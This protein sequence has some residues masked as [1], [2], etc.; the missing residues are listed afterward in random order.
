MMLV[1][2]IA[3]LHEVEASAGRTS[4][5]EGI[6]GRKVR[7]DHSRGQATECKNAICTDQS[8]KAFSQRPDLEGTTTSQQVQFVLLDV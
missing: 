7:A 4:R 6:V 2:R 5:L 8:T 1:T 3:P